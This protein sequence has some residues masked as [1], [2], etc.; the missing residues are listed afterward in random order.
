MQLTFL[1]YRELYV[2]P[3]INVTYSFGWND[4]FCKKKK[5]KNTAMGLT[6][7]QQYLLNKQKMFVSILNVFFFLSRNTMPIETIRQSRKPS[8]T[9][10]SS[11]EFFV[12]TRW[13]G[14]HTF[15]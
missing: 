1:S 3:K 2:H 5:S 13:N 8:W 6:T 10:Q 7:T 11:P 4:L 9:N 12:F 14:M 15:Q